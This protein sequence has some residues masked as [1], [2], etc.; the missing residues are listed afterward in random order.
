MSTA[1]GAIPRGATDFLSF[2]S[3]RFTVARSTKRGS[4]ASSTT[5]I[6]APVA[7]ASGTAWT[8]EAARQRAIETKHDGIQRGGIQRGSIRRSGTEEASGMG[9]TSSNTVIDLAT[10]VWEI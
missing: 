9:I 4:I 6:A 2:S 8:V 5:V 3:L 10:G 7:A 1:A